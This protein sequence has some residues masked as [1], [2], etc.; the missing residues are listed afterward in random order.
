MTASTSTSAA[1]PVAELT[2]FVRA[3][4]LRAGLADE[5]AAT[6]AEPLVLADMMGVHTHGTRLLAGYLR[7][8]LG[9]GYRPQG[10]PRIL[11]DGPAWAVVD[12]DA[13]LGQVGCTMGM[14]LAIAKAKQ[15]GVATVAVRNTGHIGAA[16][17][18][19]VLAARAGCLGIV[20]GNDVPSVTAPGSR[21]A[22]L[23]SNPLAWAA[24]RPDGDPL[25]FDV[26]T[27]AV[28]GGKVYA[29]VSRGEPIPGD[30][31]IGEDGRPTTDGTLYPAR[32]ALAP[33]AGHKGYGFGL[34]TEI[35][36][37]VMSGGA[38]VSEVGSWM[39]DPAD[40][41]SRHSAGF[42]VYD[43][44]AICDPAAYAEAM[45][46]VVR[47]VHEAPTAEGVDRVLLPGE[48]EWS[49]CRAAE[50][51]GVSLPADVRERLAAAAALVG[52]KDYRA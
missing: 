1:I 47:E 15:V 51:A 34:L 43:L 20:A 37:G 39:A 52:L 10:V 40:V 35:L 14:R 25:L 46:R 18:Y 8:L 9:G 31:L 13:A 41:P 19:A 4:G 17:F 26:S 38:V 42:T 27:A 33:M 36:S 11:R 29:A 28:A 2:A 12:G 45:R 6:L 3:A 50:A 49:R 7:K 44:A 30:W 32:A 23:G 16:G 5:A 48:R 22:V 24:P 21:R